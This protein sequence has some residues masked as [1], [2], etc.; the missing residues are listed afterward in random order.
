M[1][2]RTG[3]RPKLRAT[4]RLFWVGLARVWAGWRHSLVI[5]TPETVLRWQRRRFREYWT[6]LSGRPT[7][8]RPP[9]HADIKALVRR[10]AAA[11]PLWGRTVRKL[12]P[13]SGR[14]MVVAQQPT[15]P[16]ATMN[17]GA[18]EA[19]VSGVINSL[20]SP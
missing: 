18:P 17:V 13:C 7:V 12:I 4:D 19:A 11:N 2:K 20:P 1:Y 14:A 15:Q 6:K 10:M 8:G 3:T 16:L 9:V 5:V